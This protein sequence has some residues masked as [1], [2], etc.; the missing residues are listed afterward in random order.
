MKKLLLISSLVAAAGFFPS[1][2]AAQAVGKVISST[3]ITREVVAPRV[4]CTKAPDGREHCSN[5]NMTE[6]SAGGYLVVYEYAG[7]QYTV[8][9]PSQPG[10]TIEL[11][12]TPMPRGVASETRRQP[13]PVYSDSRIE[14]RTEPRYTERV[15][16][17]PVYSSEPRV[18][19]RVVV[20]P[21]YVDRPYYYSSPY[22]SSYYNPW[23]PILGVA[24][25]YSIGRHSNH[26]H[27]W[28]HHSHHRGHGRR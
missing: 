19:D 4:T 23:Y 15:Y 7:K 6:G 24:L 26:H 22:Y 10:A 13:R 25:G 8:E 2:A 17:E 21:V 12:V 27:G 1:L 14:T 3:P 9:M 16:S 28:R 11:E 20:E 5:V 18:V